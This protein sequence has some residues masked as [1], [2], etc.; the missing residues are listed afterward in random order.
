MRGTTYA[1]LRIVDAER[2]ISLLLHSLARLE[3]SLFYLL[4]STARLI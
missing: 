4:L 2:W 3:T 1:Q